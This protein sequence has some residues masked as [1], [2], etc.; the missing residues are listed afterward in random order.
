ML[1]VVEVGTAGDVAVAMSQMRMWLDHHRCE[2]NQFRSFRES[3]GSGFRLDFESESEATAFAN[4]FKGRVLQQE[5]AHRSEPFPE[6]PSYHRRY[7]LRGE[8]HR[9]R[10]LAARSNRPW[11]ELATR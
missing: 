5:L 11:I 9:K 2:P 4:A 6:V 7:R 1:R 8:P 3:S 10:R